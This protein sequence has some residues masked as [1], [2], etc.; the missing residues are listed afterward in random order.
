MDF[1]EAEKVVLLP[2][3]VAYPIGFTF[4]ACSSE[5]ANNGSIPFGS[6]VAS[7]VINVYQPAGPAVEGVA[8]TVNVVGGLVVNTNLTYPA[9]SDPPKGG[10]LTHIVLTLSPPGPVLVK[11]WEGLRVE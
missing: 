7:A 4:A 10:Y 2:G 6:T 5:N 11:V 3:T 9:G 8:G 1:I